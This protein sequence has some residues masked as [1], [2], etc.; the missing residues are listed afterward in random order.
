L[1][2]L[3]SLMMASEVNSFFWLRTELPV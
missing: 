2:L 3:L 1:Q